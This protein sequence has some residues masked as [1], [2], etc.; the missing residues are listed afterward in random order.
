ME[1]LK[2][3]K[4]VLVLGLVLGLSIVIG[5]KIMATPP[6]P[7]Q[8]SVT[9]EAKVDSLPQIATFNAT[10]SEFNADKDIA[11]NTV[12]TKMTA[13][14]TAIKEFG[15]DEADITTQQVSVYETGGG[16]EIMIYP[17][18]PGQI[19]PGW[20]ASN[21]IEVTLR[22]IDR[23]SELTD[24]MQSSGATNVY[25]PNFALDDTTDID[26]QLLEEAIAD[27]REKG[28]ITARAAGRRLGK[29]INVSEFDTVMPYYAEARA[30]G[31][32][33]KSMPAPIEPGTQTT[34]KQVSVLFELK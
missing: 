7:A 18:Q 8:I 33:D 23:A 32:A 2:D 4:Q 10:V 1:W 16:P 30:L 17:P 26:Q 28:E 12:N 9:G 22:D 34:T 5:A 19:Q 6:Q 24:L 31:G 25:G 29:V 21:S 14:V 27:A 20:Q 15:I 13:L 3:I 11:M